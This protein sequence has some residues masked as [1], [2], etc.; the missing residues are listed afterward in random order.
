LSPAYGKEGIIDLEAQYPVA[1]SQSGSDRINAL[2]N[3][4][5]A[6]MEDL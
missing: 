5:A 6:T 1:V 4:D 2:A 3:S